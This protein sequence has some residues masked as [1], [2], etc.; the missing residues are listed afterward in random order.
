MT[1]LT[2]QKN[3]LEGT[4]DYLAQFAAEETEA[5]KHLSDSP[6]ATQLIQR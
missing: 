6:K 3:S 5:R 2:E 1:F 4:T